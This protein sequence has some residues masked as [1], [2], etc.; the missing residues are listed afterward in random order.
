[1][2]ATIVAPHAN[3]SENEEMIRK[4]SNFINPLSK[5]KLLRSCGAKNK[6]KDANMFTQN[7]AN[8]LT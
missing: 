1:M 5:P 4:W 2:G 3:A 6:S 7:P 8:M